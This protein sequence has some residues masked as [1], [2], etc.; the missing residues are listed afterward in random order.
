M[1]ETIGAIKGTSLSILFD[2][3]ATYSFISPSIVGKCSLEVVKQGIGWQVKLASRTKV[4]TDSLIQQC[5]LDLR[6]FTTSVD[7]QVIPLGSYDI[8][9]GMDWLGSK[10]VSIDCRK[11]TIRCKD[12]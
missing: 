12:D 4:S 10:R 3:S 1:V 7:L 6:E 5:K 8:V 11:K 2:S 9:L